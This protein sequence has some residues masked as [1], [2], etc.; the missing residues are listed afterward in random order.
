MGDGNLNI[1]EYLDITWGRWIVITIMVLLI[2][3]LIRLLKNW[4]EKA[5]LLGGWNDRI[6]RFVRK[7]F[8]MSE[9]VGGLIVIGSFVLINPIVHG[10]LAL[11]I[12]I[13]GYG[14][15]RSYFTG[16]VLQMSYAFFK[17]QKIKVKDNEGIIQEIG[18]TSLTLQTKQGAE[19][20]L[21]LIHI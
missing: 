21:S 13:L 12:L 20:I 11:V 6:Y 7:F 9:P 18:R 2:Y 17:G 15:V 19:Y 4:L 14:I 5:S 10:T 8:I 3:W 1:I 16:K